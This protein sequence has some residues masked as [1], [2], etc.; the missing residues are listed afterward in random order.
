MNEPINSLGKFLNGWFEVGT[1]ALQ[2]KGMKVALSNAFSTDGK[3]L[4]KQAKNVNGDLMFQTDKKTGKSILDANGKQIPVMQ[5]DTSN[6]NWSKTIG[7][8]WAAGTA[9]SIGFGAVKGALTDSNGDFD[10]PGV[11]FI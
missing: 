6:L 9:A 7:S 10:M 11:P 3:S 5:F 8:T 4:W 2:G 1:D